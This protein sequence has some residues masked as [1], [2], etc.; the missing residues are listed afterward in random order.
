MGMVGS[1]GPMPPASKQMTRFGEPV[2]WASMA[3]A[4]GTPVPT[5]TVRPSS[6]RRAAQQIISSIGV[7]VIT[8]SHVLAVQEELVPAEFL[9]P[10]EAATALQ[11]LGKVA[12]AENVGLQ[13][14]PIR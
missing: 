13:E 2:R 14:L 7:Y 12:D 8:Q 11:V 6:S 5:A 9:Q 1:W 3:A 4:Q 10:L